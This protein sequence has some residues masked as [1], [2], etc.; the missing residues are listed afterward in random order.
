MYLIIPTASLL[1]KQTKKFIKTRKKLKKIGKK[2]RKL[3]K[4]LEEGSIVYCRLLEE[5]SAAD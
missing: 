4:V 2:T 3:S 1:L 5:R